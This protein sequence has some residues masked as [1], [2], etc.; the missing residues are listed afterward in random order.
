MDDGFSF[1]GNISKFDV[2]GDRELTIEDA[3][4]HGSVEAKIWWKKVMEPYCRSQITPEMKQIF[5]DKVIGAYQGKALVP[6]EPGSDARP[7]ND[8]GFLVDKL[9]VT[10]GLDLFSAQKVAGKINQMKYG[11]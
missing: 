9:R 3:P 6:G 8:F 1:D 2:D 10:Q 5:G 4:P 7:Q 11:G